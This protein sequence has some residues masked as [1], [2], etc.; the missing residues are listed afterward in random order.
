MQE[1][2]VGKE[3]TGFPT[4]LVATTSDATRDALAEQLGQDG[5]LVLTAVDALEALIVV[6][7][8]SR[9]INVL[10][11]DDQTLPGL[12]RPYRLAMHSVLV[13]DQHHENASAKTL[14]EVVA[15]VR[16]CLQRT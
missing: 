4:I 7:V 13:I 8:H 10:V 1:L 2:G 3:K 5:Y 12:L 6:Q 11:T 16:R 15:E 14:A 9:P